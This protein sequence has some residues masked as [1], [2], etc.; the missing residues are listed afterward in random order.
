MI[1]ASVLAQPLALWRGSADAQ[2]PAAIADSLVLNGG[3]AGN[4][5]SC[6]H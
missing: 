1:E 3:R 6:R 4:T 5:L 2:Q